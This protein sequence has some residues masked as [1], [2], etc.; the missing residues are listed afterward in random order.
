MRYIKKV[1]LIIFVYL[2]FYKPEL[3]FVPSSLNF[4]FGCI[5]FLLY[6]F[7]PNLRN[8]IIRDSGLSIK[9]L[10][11]Y[12]TPFLIIAIF[13]CAINF[14]TDIYYIKYFFSLILGFYFSYL[15][16]SLFYNIYNEITTKKIIEYILVAQLIYMLLSI[17]MFINP[18]I[19]STLISLLKLNLGAEY[20]Y[21]NTQGLRLLGWGA[22]FFASGIING[23]VLILLSIYINIYKHTNIKQILLYLLFIFIFI[24]GMMMARTCLIGAS[25]AILILLNYWR[26]SSIKFFKT[27][28]ILFFIIFISTLILTKLS[29]SIA[30]EIEILS[31]FAFE[32]FINYNENGTLSS[33]SS[34]R[35]IEMYET[36]PNN[37]KTWTIG[38]AKWTGDDGLYYMNTDVGYFRNIFYFGIIGQLSLII[39]YI[40][41]L[42]YIIVPKN[43]FGTSS[44]MICLLLFCFILIINLK[45]IADLYF[46]IIPFIFITKH[47]YTR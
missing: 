27:L 14:S 35:L 26:K 47:V 34:D 33:A 2:L 42:K 10:L 18:N 8:R 23:F 7:N 5:G 30:E 40:N 20:A 1:L 24:I 45:G 44:K 9:R 41:I 37:L 36:L 29:N 32:M 17:L 22:S 11:K 31:N 16:I 19:N 43:I 39:Y 38:D 28:L 13:S 15:V 6:I 46:Y 25:F 12:S 3:Y 21:E 4:T